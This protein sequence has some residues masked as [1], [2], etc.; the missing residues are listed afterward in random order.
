MQS[1]IGEQLKYAVT[2]AEKTILRCYKR[3]GVVVVAIVVVVALVVV[4]Q[5]I[6]IRFKT[7]SYYFKYT[8]FVCSF[9]H[10]SLLS[11]QCI[12]LPFG[13]YTL[14]YHNDIIYDEF[15]LKLAGVY[16]ILAV[17]SSE[18]KLFRVRKTFVCENLKEVTGLI[19]NLANSFLLQL[20]TNRYFYNSSFML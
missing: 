2:S 15:D 12:R 3:V 16:Y 14:V 8:L 1:I 4:K 13:L 11:N 20:V 19:R 17:K 18:R 10:L 7:E 9:D 5:A 6:N